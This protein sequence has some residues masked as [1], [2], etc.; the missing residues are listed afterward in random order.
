MKKL[1]LMGSMLLCMLL[2]CGAVQRG[3]CSGA[4]CEDTTVCDI[5]KDSDEA[6]V[7]AAPMSRMRMLEAPAADETAAAGVN[8]QVNQYRMVQNIIDSG[9]GAEKTQAISLVAQML[10]E[11]GMEKAFIAGV[12]GNILCEG[13][14]GMF[15][16]DWGGGLQE[17]LPSRMHGDPYKYSSRY[18]NKL[19][20]NGY[21]LSKVYKMT[22]DLYY[23]FDW[24]RGRYMFGLG[25]VQWTQ[26]RTMQLME[27]YIAEA[28]GN[29]TITE[30]QCIA[31]EMKFIRHELTETETGAY[32]HWSAGDHKNK[33]K[34]DAERAGYCVA[35]YYERC[36]SSYYFMR[37]ETSLAVYEVMHGRMKD[38]AVIQKDTVQR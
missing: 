28:G 9:I 13:R 11:E 22:K 8:R 12:C 2:M 10:F 20:Y 6:A 29:D 7:A 5:Q 15:E 17:Y 14:I 36:S 18:G 3:H 31:A 1:L 16:R 26:K 4:A 19:I 35:R 34:H 30:E 23:N 33:Y 32:E 27:Y 21:S 37:A 25:C 24:H 38:N